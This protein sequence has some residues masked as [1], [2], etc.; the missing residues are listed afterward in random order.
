[1]ID[2]RQIPV[3]T[4]D[5]P[6]GSGKGTIAARLASKLGWHLLDSGALYRILAYQAI[7]QGTSL[8]AEPELGEMAKKMPIEF[9]RVGTE[10]VPYLEGTA[11]GREIRTEA[12]GAVAS[13]IASLVAVRDG[14][15]QRQRDF[16][17]QPGLVADGRDMGTVVFP[18]APLKLYLTAS[19]EVRAERRF[20][21]LK[22]K[23]QEASLAQLVDD[24]KM[25]DDRDMN[26]AVAPLKPAEGAI[27]L[28]SSDMDIEQVMAFV[29][30]HAGQFERTISE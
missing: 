30:Q 8:E 20:L 22:E 19:A 14:L 4:I 11:I 27:L 29:W 3:I 17:Q 12:V 16:L 13:K 6:S 5:G 10:V 7:Q 9:K 21:Q 25:R 24:I 1:M 23:G 18:N 28:D 26:R 15:L 2:E